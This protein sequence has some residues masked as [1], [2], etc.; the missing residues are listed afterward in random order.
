MQTG[1]H[2]RRDWGD[3]V[4]YFADPNGHIIAFAETIG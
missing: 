2:S 1:M 3:R 4:C